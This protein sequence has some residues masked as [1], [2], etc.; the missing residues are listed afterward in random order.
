MDFSLRLLR[1]QHK[2]EWLERTRF[3]NTSFRDTYESYE[4]SPRIDSYEQPPCLGSRFSEANRKSN[5]VCQGIVDG[6]VEINHKLDEALGLLLT[7]PKKI[8]EEDLAKHEH[9]EQKDLGFKIN[10]FESQRTHDESFRQVEHSYQ[11]IENDSYESEQEF[12]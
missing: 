10:D 8:V 1:L 11:V 2:V 5:L 6:A 12:E 3:Q 7:L 4:P 9:I